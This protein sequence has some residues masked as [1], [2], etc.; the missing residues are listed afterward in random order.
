MKIYLNSND[1]L[2][3]SNPEPFEGKILS[4]EDLQGFIHE[5][6]M[7]FKQPIIIFGANWC[8]DARLLDRTLQLPTIKKFLDDR[9]QILNI[10]VGQYELNINLLQWFDPSIESGI[11]RVFILNLDGETLNLDCNEKMRTARDQSSQE[12]FNY[13]Q[14]FILPA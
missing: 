1:A 12:I 4:L 13:F 2:N 10:D 8:P 9:C 3:N 6:S 7:Q 5:A 11:P 14:D